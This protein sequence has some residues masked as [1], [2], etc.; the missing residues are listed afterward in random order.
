MVGNR[1]DVPI[2]SNYNLRRCASNQIGRKSESNFFAFP[3]FTNKE[4]IFKMGKKNMYLPS[5]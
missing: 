5:R 3:N 4:K 2:L 1:N